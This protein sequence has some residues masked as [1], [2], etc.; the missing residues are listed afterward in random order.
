MYAI[1]IL[2]YHVCNTTNISGQIEKPFHQLIII[3]LYIITFHFYIIVTFNYLFKLHITFTLSYNSIY[4]FSMGYIF[5]FTILCCILINQIILFLV[6]GLSS[7]VV[8][9]SPLLPVSPGRSLP[10]LY[11]HSNTGSDGSASSAA[12]HTHIHYTPHPQTNTL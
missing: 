8:G 12:L 6:S 9:Y 10:V 1:M 7:N 3:S 5:K 2:S 11:S 4:V